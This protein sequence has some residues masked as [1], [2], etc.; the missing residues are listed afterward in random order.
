MSSGPAP[1]LCFLAAT[2]L[3]PPSC[4]TESVEKIGRGCGFLVNKGTIHVSDYL[5][6]L[7]IQPRNQS[8]TRPSILGE[9]QIFRLW[10]D[11]WPLKNGTEHHVHVHHAHIHHAHVHVH[12]VHVHHVMLL[13]N[14]AYIGSWKHFV[15]F[16]V[17]VCVSLSLYFCRSS[18]WSLS[19]PDDKLSENI[20]FVWSRTSY[21]GDKWRCHHADRRTNEQVKIELLSQWTVWDWV[22]QFINSSLKEQKK[23][24]FSWGSII[25]S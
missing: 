17:C 9:S 16:F 23:E 22:S 1:H 19:S 18:S 6:T 20:W 24:Q 2:S 8:I 21:G 13:K 11:Q 4:Q 5:S 10:L 3:T 14:I 7:N 12:H 15:F 25:Q